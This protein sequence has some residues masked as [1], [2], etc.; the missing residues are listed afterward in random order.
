MMLS[1]TTTHCRPSGFDAGCIDQG[2]Q[3][4]QQEAKEVGPAHDVEHL[5][6]TG[7]LTPGLTT[8]TTTLLRHPLLR[9]CFPSGALCVHR[10]C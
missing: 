8:V 1:S 7:A 3:Q 10:V 4:H 5:G 9:P 2:C 6:L